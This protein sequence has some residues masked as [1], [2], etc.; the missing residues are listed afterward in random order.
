MIRKIVSFAIHQPLFL[1]LL[2]PL[3]TGAGILAFRSLPIEAF[4]DD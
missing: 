4:P 3:F 2:L 1:V